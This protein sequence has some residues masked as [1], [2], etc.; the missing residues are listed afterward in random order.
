MV[1]LLIAVVAVP[2]GMV[3]VVFAFALARVAAKPTPP[4]CG[5]VGEDRDA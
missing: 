2:L 3:A 4:V 5:P 1:V